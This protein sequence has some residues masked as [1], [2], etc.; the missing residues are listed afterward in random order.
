MPDDEKEVIEQTDD[1]EEQTGTPSESQDDFSVGFSDKEPTEKESKAKAE[2]KSEEKPE[3]KPVEKRKPGR[4]PKAKTPPKEDETPK[5]EEK[6]EKKAEP[7]PKPEPKPKV[8]DKKPEEK[9]EED[10]EDLDEDE[11]RGKALL[12]VEEKNQKAAEEEKKKTEEATKKA[13]ASQQPKIKPFPKV[14]NNLASLYFQFA[15]LDNLPDLV[16]IGDRELALKGYAE[17]NPEMVVIASNVAANVVQR[18]IDNGFLVTSDNQKA[19]VEQFKG[20]MQSQLFHFAVASQI[21]EPEKLWDSKEF[22]EWHKEQP[23]TIQALFRSGDPVDHVRGFK[24][25]LAR[26]TDEV[27]EKAGMHDKKMSDV[28]KKHDALHSTTIR[29]TPAKMTQALY[30]AED[31]FSEGFHEEEEK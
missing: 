6:V 7:K 25:Y 5:P 14:D 30:E 13:E 20:D 8:E 31:E 10:Q 23:E 27:K 21:P 1:N 29:P 15:P 28:K 11:V 26:A 22:Q 12:E 16:K 4:P 19:T 3:E 18:L 9:P 2:P 24:R 17:D